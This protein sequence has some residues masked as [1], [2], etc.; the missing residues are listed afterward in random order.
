MTAGIAGGWFR[1]YEAAAP[2]ERL[3][4]LPHAGGSAAFYRRWGASFGPE[5][6]VLVA[7]YP[8][9][10]T[11]LDEPLLRTMDE[12]ADAVTAALLPFTDLPLSLF[13][14]SMGASLAHEVA[15]RLEARHS[16]R[17][18]GLHVSSRR[19]PHRLTA[20][21]LHLADDRTLIDEVVRLGG[22]DA[23]A[24]ADPG[25]RAM[26]LPVIRADFEIAGTYG[27]RA[28]VPV[29]CP[30]H[31]YAGDRDPAVSPADL[32]AWA[33]IAPAGFRRRLFPGGH[34]YLVDRHAELTGELG[35]SLAGV[36]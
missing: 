36:R 30:V 10:H 18:A 34:F 1:R 31:A 20:R 19:P 4:V 8:G 16:V 11:R 17:L 28:A 14:H 29:G 23:S 22:T 25:L 21:G 24:L 7:C 26:V 5:T 15:L 2:G 9:R 6:D 35:R 32:A 33:D 27:P 3:V 12:L 13:G